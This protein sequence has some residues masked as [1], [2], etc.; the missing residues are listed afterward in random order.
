MEEARSNCSFKICDCEE[1]DGR[2][3]R[4]NGQQKGFYHIPHVERWVTRVKDPS[5]MAVSCTGLQ[6]LQ[7]HSPLHSVPPQPLWPRHQP[8]RE[9]GGSGVFIPP[10]LPQA[11]CNAGWLLL[12]PWG[13]GLNPKDSVFP[14]S[15]SPRPR[16]VGP[17]RPSSPCWFPQTCPPLTKWFLESPWLPSSACLLPEPEQIH[18]TLSRT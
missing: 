17:G 11:H 5:V 4:I 6:S 8:E 14:S 3:M 13:A 2:R 9:D 12:R 7:I 15:R 1:R 16:G 18:T 10:P